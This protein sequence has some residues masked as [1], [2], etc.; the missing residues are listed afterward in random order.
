MS[1]NTLYKA[2]SVYFQG[3]CCVVRNAAR[4]E[5]TTEA[6][7]LLLAAQ[8]SNTPDL[9]PHT[10]VLTFDHEDYIQ[11]LPADGIQL[12]HRTCLTPNHRIEEYDAGAGRPR[13]SLAFLDLTGMELTVAGAQGNKLKLGKFFLK[14]W[15]CLDLYNVGDTNGIDPCQMHDP[16]PNTLVA[17]RVH[18]CDGTLDSTVRVGGPKAGK[19]ALDLPGSNP[20][21]GQEVVFSQE[22]RYDYFTQV[23]PAK[24][25]LEFRPFGQVSPTHALHLRTGAKIGVSCLCPISLREDEAKDFLAYYDLLLSPPAAPLRPVRIQNL[26]P[27]KPSSSACPPSTSFV[28]TT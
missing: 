27:A 1:N 6:T 2:L 9:C 20:Q 21:P 17:G 28:G 23:E 16:P 13:R 19:W 7:L 18:L 25:S 22:L 3:L 4:P 10:P 26:N 8:Y 12:P 24:V 5:D 11:E 15:P 14:N